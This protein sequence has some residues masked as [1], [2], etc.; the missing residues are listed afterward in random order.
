L[1]DKAQVLIFAA[2][3]VEIE[4]GFGFPECGARSSQFS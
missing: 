1:P 2:Y 3:F 4:T